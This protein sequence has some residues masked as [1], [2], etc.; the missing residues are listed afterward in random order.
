MVLV[1]RVVDERVV[2]VPRVVDGRQGGFVRSTM[3]GSTVCSQ[4]VDAYLA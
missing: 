2:L 3:A 4:N 1:P